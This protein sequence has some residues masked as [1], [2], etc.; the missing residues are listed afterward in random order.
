M[1]NKMLYAQGCAQEAR[2]DCGKQAMVEA[3]CGNVSLD[4]TRLPS[5]GYPVP[6][7]AV[8]VLEHCLTGSS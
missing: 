1:V 8:A 5:A 7:L 6:I 4:T 3:S 2:S